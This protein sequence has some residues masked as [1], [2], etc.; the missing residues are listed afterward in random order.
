MVGS[1]AC[2]ETPPAF[3]EADGIELVDEEDGDDTEGGE[4]DDEAL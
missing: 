3:A 4:L 2:V 1:S